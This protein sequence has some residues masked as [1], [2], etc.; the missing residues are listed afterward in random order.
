M[1]MA[2]GAQA[3]PEEPGPLEAR[4]VRVGFGRCL[5]AWRLTYQAARM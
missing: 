4:G 3:G 5:L 1:P 2:S